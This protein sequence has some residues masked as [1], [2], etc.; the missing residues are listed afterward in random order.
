MSTTSNPQPK[1]WYNF[2]PDTATEEERNEYIVWR[3][4][5]YR[6]RAKQPR[7]PLD[8]LFM[9]DYEIWTLEQLSKVDNQTLHDLRT[10]LR[11][12][13]IYVKK[14]KGYK[15][16]KAIHKAAMGVISTDWPDNEPREDGAV[17][18]QVST[19]LTI[20]GPT[21]SPTPGPTSSHT[22]GPTP[23]SG[24]H[25]YNI[26]TSPSQ[27]KADQHSPQPLAVNS[28]LLSATTPRP[29]PEP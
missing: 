6:Q 27:E 10:V 2:S 25:Q 14:Q 3:T 12:A 11:S 4:N 9:D 15:V 13:G 17:Q 18:P 16:A 1:N 19:S 22:P 7:Y 21:S 20:P 5:I 26:N 29:M 8:E 28:A 23:G 24:Y